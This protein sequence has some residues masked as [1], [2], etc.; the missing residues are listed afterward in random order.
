MNE[1]STSNRK[2]MTRMLN[3]GKSIRINILRIFE[4]NIS[5][6]HSRASHYVTKLK[7]KTLPAEGNHDLPAFS[8]KAMTR[9]EMAK[10]GNSRAEGRSIEE[11]SDEVVTVST[12]HYSGVKLAE[13][14][15]GVEL[16]DGNGRPGRMSAVRKEN[17][18]E[19]GRLP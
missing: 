16:M 18:P 5:L 14:N 1:I 17:R 6:L 10:R 7:L 13:S 2:N 9:R 11:D 8:L 19:S 4:I 15:G 3:I 12:A